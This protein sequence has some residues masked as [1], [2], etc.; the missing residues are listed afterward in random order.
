VPQARARAGGSRKPAC[1]R[2]EL[3]L[4][5]RGGARVGAVLLALH[6]HADS[7]L[8]HADCFVT[9]RALHLKTG[10]QQHAHAWALGELVRVAGEP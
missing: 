8:K 6:L 10:A 3:V 1:A 5:A 7:E 2:R 9:T 4:I